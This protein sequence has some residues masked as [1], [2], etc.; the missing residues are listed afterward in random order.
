MVGVQAQPAAPGLGAPPGGL[1]PYTHGDL[2]QVAFLDRVL[3]HCDRFLA[4]TGHHWFAT[5]ATS[6]C[7]HWL[8]RMVG[9]DLAVDR[10]DFPPLA[11]S[12]N[13]PGRRRFLYI[14]HDG[15]YKNLGYLA[16]I[17][18]ALPAGTVAW[19]GRGKRRWPGLG[20]LGFH[21]FSTT[22]GR[23]VLADFDFLITVGRADANPTTV[24]EAMAW[25]LIP[26]CTPQSGYDDEAGVV[27][28]PLDDLPGAL[29][30]LQRLQS[31]DDAGLRAMQV[32]NN[33]RLEAHFTWGRFAGQVRRRRHY[34]PPGDGRARSRQPPAHALGGAELAVVLR[35]FPEP[36]A[37]AQ[38][39][40]ARLMRG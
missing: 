2:S 25:G 28:V 34:R 11:R 9:L 5:T 10:A 27:N 6:P 20:E 1:A 40:P 17:A 31:S 23:A 22:A 13:P 21:D 12:F 8:P 39:A 26:V 30:V 29:A 35:A 37:R 16:A 7:A 15:W 33:A 36:A 14:G 24:L 18:R 3:P 4:I 38:A 32:A 19:A